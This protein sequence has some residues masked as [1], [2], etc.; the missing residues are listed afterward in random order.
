MTYIEVAEFK[1]LTG[2]SLSDTDIGYILQT[3]DRDVN[4]ELSALENTSLSADCLHNAALLFA[5]AALADRYRFD[6]TFDASTTDYSHK[7]NAEATITSLKAEARLII[8]N[9]A[10]K[11]ILWI[12]KANR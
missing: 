3:A 9:E 12:Q 1:A 11:S 2:C 10:A 8:R 6:G 7:G 5:R 4:N